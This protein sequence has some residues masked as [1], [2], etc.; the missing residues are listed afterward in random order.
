MI[1]EDD[2]LAS[3]RRIA[4]AELTA[5]VEHGWVMP[6]RRGGACYYSELDIARVRL[7]AE[8]R[9][10]LNLD[11]EALEV[12]L[13]L[14]DQVYGLRRQLRAVLDA[15]A[16]EPEPVRGRIAERLRQRAESETA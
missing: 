13:P 7:I 8:M 5:W 12:V 1:P 9:Q 14:L 2:V 15:L 11:E 16:A 3:V 4:R 6:A 10:D